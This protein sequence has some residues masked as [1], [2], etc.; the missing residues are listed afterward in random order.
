MHVATGEVRARRVIA[1]LGL[2]VLTSCGGIGDTEQSA[3]NQAERSSQFPDSVETLGDSTSQYPISV[4]E[5]LKRRCGVLLTRV[6]TL[7]DPDQTG[8]LSD[9]PTVIKLRNGSFLS[10]ARTRHRML[11][12]DSAG[13][14]SRTVGS[15]G[16]GPGEFMLATMPVLGP[17]DSVFVFDVGLQRLTVFTP[18]L[19]FARSILALRGPSLILDDGTFVVADHV[20]S[21]DAVGYP[22]HRANPSGS[23][24]FS[25][26]ADTP[27]FRFD[28]PLATE[29]VVTYGAA[30]SI[31]AA[32][33]GSYSLEQWDARSG[34]RLYRVPVQAEWF[35]EALRYQGDGER[36]VSIVQSL[37]DGGPNLIWV[38]IR[39]ADAAWMPP[40]DTVWER[41]WDA[42]EYDA[43][44][45]WILDAV[46]VPTGRVLASHRFERA[47]R[48]A[49]GASFLVSRAASTLAPTTFDVW[50][51]SLTPM[52]N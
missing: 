3:L 46:H 6:G 2:A 36:P 20:G 44:H 25:F 42:D 23:I 41:R 50:R 38:L 31:W 11:V 49:N 32:R 29:H 15:Q 18:D 10:M 26:G 19:S 48:V 51:A 27:H 22:L 13:S 4:G 5:C 8:L 39:V 47:T 17:G 1:A 37:I 40:A 43:D 28:L 30:G 7:E 33:R 52:E 24:E 34:R 35:S 12:Y 16:Q 14:L 21:A 45:D 9:R